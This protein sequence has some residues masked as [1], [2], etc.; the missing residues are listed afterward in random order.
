M[1]II[2]LVVGKTTENWIESGIK[3]YQR[4]LKHY[5]KFDFEIIPDVKAGKRRGE[6]IKRI[7]GEQILNFIDTTDHVILLD[8]HGKNYSSRKFSAQLQKWMNASP[9]RLIFVV[10]GAFGFSED[11]K[12]RAKESLSLSNMTFTHQMI[13]PFFIEQLYRSF[14]ILRGEKYHND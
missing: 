6:E 13:R 3:E 2:L 14:T 11:V 7:E 8:E 5:V 12:A 4:R 1:Q 9:K 10:G